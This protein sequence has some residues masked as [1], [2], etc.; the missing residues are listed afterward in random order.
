MENLD[1]LDFRLQDEIW[2]NKKF[3]LKS[4]KK[5]SSSSTPF[6]MRKGSV[7]FQTFSLA[8]TWLILLRI[9]LLNM[10]FPF[11]IGKNITI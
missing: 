1:W 3:R 5:K 8:I 7:T 11:V 4:K 9:L 10:T 2:W 6:G